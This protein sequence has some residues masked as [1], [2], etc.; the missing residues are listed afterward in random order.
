MKEIPLFGPLGLVEKASWLG[1]NFIY[2][3]EGNGSP[4]TSLRMYDIQTKSELTLFDIGPSG[5]FIKTKM[6][7]V[8]DGKVILLVWSELDGVRSVSGHD[9]EKLVEKSKA[10]DTENPVWK[11]IL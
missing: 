2:V 1:N 10:S 11:I 6:V 4:D 5:S 8:G 9:L 7:Q 3:A